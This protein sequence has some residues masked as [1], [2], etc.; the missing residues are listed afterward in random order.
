MPGARN[1]KGL[2]DEISGN[3]EGKPFTTIDDDVIM[4]QSAAAHRWRAKSELTATVV[5][6]MINLFI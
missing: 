4:D 2:R 5:G 6:K 3:L 1:E